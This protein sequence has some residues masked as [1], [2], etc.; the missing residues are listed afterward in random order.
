LRFKT[1]MMEMNI[2]TE[3]EM[4]NGTKTDTDM[5]TETETKPETDVDSIGEGDNDYNQDRNGDR[6]QGSKGRRPM[7]SLY[8]VF[9]IFTR[10]FQL[11]LWC[12]HLF[13]VWYPTQSLGNT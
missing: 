13:S 5:D 1:S 12:Q 3:T 4:E 8:M 7:L 11:L 2:E 6:N 9:L 10:V